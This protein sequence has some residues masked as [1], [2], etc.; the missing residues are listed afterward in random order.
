MTDADKLL[1]VCRVVWPAKKWMIYT[2]AY[3]W[4]QEAGDCFTPGYGGTKFLPTSTDDLRRILL[5]LTP[6]QV[7]DFE[8]E[9]AQ[10]LVDKDRPHETL[11]TCL[12]FAALTAPTTQILDALHRAVCPA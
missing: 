4:V 12:Y 3:A 6:G 7:E 5:A 9:V 8:T 10:A 11:G 2:A 1:A